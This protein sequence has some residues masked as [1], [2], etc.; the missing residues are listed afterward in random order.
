MPRF[1]SASRSRPRRA[2]AAAGF[3]PL[4]AAILAIPVAA[5]G[6]TS[7]PDALSSSEEW[8]RA[9]DGL[10]HSPVLQALVDAQIERDAG[11]LVAALDDPDPAVRARAAFALG[12]VQDPAAASE[13]IAALEDPDPRVRADAAFALGQSADSTVSERLL[14]ALAEETAPAAR[15]QLFEALGKTGDGASLRRL[16]GLVV[17]PGDRGALALAI[18]RYGFRGVHDPAAVRRLVTMLPGDLDDALGPPED[19]AV[20]D[21]A[22]WYFG[23]VQDTT[24]WAF[25][26]GDLRSAVDARFL[27][28]S[29]RAAPGA[30]ERSDGARAPDLGTAP[31]L[32]LLAAL[33]RLGDP[34]DDERLIDWLE[35]AVD[36]RARVNAAR[37]LAGRTEREAVRQA[38]LA[39]ARDPSVHVAVE[40]ARALATAD[41]LPLETRRTIS[42]RYL[43]NALAWQV[44]AA[45]TP[46]IVKGGGTGV[47]LLVL[48]GITGGEAPNNPP[49]RADLL[50][51]LGLD[52]RR[53]GWLM[54]RFEAAAEDPMVAAAAIA[55]LAER[56]RRGYRSDE[57]TVDEYY[58]LFAAALERK[59]LATTSAAAPPLADSLFRPLGATGLLGR[60]YRELS[61]PHDIE[62]M[63]EILRALG[64]TG[65]PAAEPVLREALV[66]SHPVLR[67]AASLALAQLGEHPVEIPAV[68]NAP[69]EIP[70]ERRVDWSFLRAMGARP[71]LAL[72]TERGRIVIELDVE[73]AP[74]TV[75]TVLQLAQQGRYDGVP[76]HRVVPNFVIQ[77]GDFERGDG[78]GG[79]GFAIRSEFTR[80]P[81]ERGVIGLASA[82]K[83]TEGS[84][85]F[86]TH[87]PQPHLDGRYTAFGHV[88]EGMEVVDL[89]LEGDRVERVSVQVRS[90][91]RAE[92]WA[93]PRDGRP[94]P[95]AY[96]RSVLEP[97]ERVAASLP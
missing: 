54:L 76:F 46:A 30:G 56:W 90:E 96:E 89:M 11:T 66:A 24:A 57:A 72:E 2:L 14:G 17:E 65:D 86:I 12:S 93:A 13:L 53:P 25:V 69:V 1:D 45:F 47:V 5:A 38:L 83:D 42:Q 32:H 21:H 4:F 29:S 33:G 39:A 3:P 61:A 19:V 82:G 7:P 41:S 55:G 77:G 88:V 71:R 15:R 84:Q 68:E 80:I 95:E 70:P 35:S 78:Y 34:Q 27:A 50:E 44:S 67:R 16:S 81:F 37:A 28:Q 36:W 64:E 18:G 51:S 43:T 60:V 74:L 52:D 73:E 20:S 40:A 49:Y 22:A 92:G 31:G 10:L 85:Y 94:S 97:A 91:G 26:A 8:G 63:V 48:T 9:T 87:S 6:Q 79:P 75:Q 23:R 58:R 62:P 59:D